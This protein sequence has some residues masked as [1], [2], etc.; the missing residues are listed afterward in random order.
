[1]QP[2]TIT[3]YKLRWIWDRKK[4]SKKGKNSAFEKRSKLQ[5]KKGR[6]FSIKKGTNLLIEK[7]TNSAIER[8]QKQIETNWNFHERDKL[9]LKKYE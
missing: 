3:N 2:E 1:M 4:I 9:K 7:G 8:I 6:K 5:I